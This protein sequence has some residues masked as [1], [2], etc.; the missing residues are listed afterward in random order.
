MIMSPLFTVLF[1][2]TEFKFPCIAISWSTGANLT[3]LASFIVA[4]LIVTSSPMDVP[5]FFLR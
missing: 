4:G 2:N 3:F 1:R 5:A